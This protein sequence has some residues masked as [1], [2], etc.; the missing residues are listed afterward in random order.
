VDS[1][2]FKPVDWANVP[3]R[4]F[5][6]DHEQ[7]IASVRKLAALEPR[8]VAAGHSEPLVGEPAE[9]RLK[10]EQAALRG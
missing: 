3:N 4:V 7:A 5:N 8:V 10:L 9:V 2:K 1:L 6:Q